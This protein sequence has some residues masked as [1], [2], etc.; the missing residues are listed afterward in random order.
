MPETMTY[1]YKVR[2]RGGK[3][4]TG[5]LAGESQPLVLGRLREMGYTPI[6]VE[7]Q[8]QGVNV[9]ITIKRKA[10]LKDLAIFSRQF[11]TMVSSGLPILKALSILEQQTES[12]VLASAVGAV[13]ADIEGGSSLSAALSR[14]PKVFS[15]L[16]VAMVKSGEAGGVLEAVLERL[17]ANLERE[18]TLRGKIKSAMTYPIVVA[19]FVSI[20]FMAML[21]FIVPQFKAIYASLGGQLPF[22]TAM[23]L[24]VSDGVKRYFIIIAV[25]FVAA[26]VLV[27]RYIKTEPGHVQ[28]DKLKLRVP[29]FGSLFRKTALARFARTLSVLNKSGVPILQGLD[30]VT[31]TV[32]NRVV[33][34]AV[35]DV[36][37]SVSQGESLA[38]PL[39]RHSI[40]PPMVVQMLA[41][42]EETGALDTMLEK[43]AAFYDEE[44]SSTVDSLTSLIEPVMIF[45]VGG[46]VGIA[47]IA[48][49]MPMFNIIKL[50]H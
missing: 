37:K 13:R 39:A 8:R 23:L 49:Y 50:I 15:D 46:A 32:N 2:D 26:V 16:Y 48:L 45:F 20:I 10:N 4:V 1:A 42:G 5:T 28:W 18:V 38:K 31:G 24:K 6:S 22:L 34:A 33:S 30:V 21:L 7:V 43:V 47:V 14:H 29:V 3:V 27:R 9:S 19:G 44:V 36:Q 17:A 25:V 41:V 35:Q 40:F 12:K 11:A